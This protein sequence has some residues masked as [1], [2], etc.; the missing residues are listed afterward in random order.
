MGADFKSGRPDKEEPVRRIDAL[1]FSMES[2]DRVDA[3]EDLKLHQ[4]LHGR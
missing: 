1:K 4:R 2:R 3:S